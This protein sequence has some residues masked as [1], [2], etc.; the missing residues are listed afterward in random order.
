MSNEINEWNDD[1]NN[2]AGVRY[3]CSDSVRIT[4]DIEAAKLS[5]TKGFTDYVNSRDDIPMDYLN[6]GVLMGWQTFFLEARFRTLK[7]RDQLAAEVQ[8]ANFSQAEKDL[9]L[10]GSEE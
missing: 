8:A 1:S 6:N 2:E 3:T 4:I 5:S 7:S 9:V 10:Y